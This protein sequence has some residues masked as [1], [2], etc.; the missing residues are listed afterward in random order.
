MTKSIDN[1]IALVSKLKESTKAGDLKWRSQNAPEALLDGTDDRIIGFFSTKFLER[2]LGLFEERF[3]TFSEDMSDSIWSRRIVL[4]VF[5]SSWN[6]LVEAPDVPGV[7]DLYLIV[8]SHEAKLD[9]FFERA[10]AV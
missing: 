5:D 4:A 6:P 10:L 2:N 3:K 8:K 9:E 7:G 1:W